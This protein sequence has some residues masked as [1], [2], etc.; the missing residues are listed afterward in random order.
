MNILPH[1]LNFSTT[2]FIL[3]MALDNFK[4]KLLDCLK[5]YLFD[6][7]AYSY[8]SFFLDFTI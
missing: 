7:S 3:N 4:H 6:F 2:N 5:K 8:V 1:I